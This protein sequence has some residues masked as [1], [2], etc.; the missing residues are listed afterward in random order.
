VA[1]HHA[2]GPFG[3]LLA[4]AFVAACSSPGEGAPATPV[5]TATGHVETACDMFTPDDLAGFLHQP[6]VGHGEG[7]TI[8]YLGVDL[9]HCT[10]TW[11]PERG[12]IDL[13]LLTAPMAEGMTEDA[14]AEACPGFIWGAPRPSA[15]FDCQNNKYRFE[16]GDQILSIDRPAD[17]VAAYLIQQSLDAHLVQFGQFGVTT[18][19]AT[20][21]L[22]VRGYSPALDGVDAEALL[23]RMHER[24]KD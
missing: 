3:I 4:A 8:A 12:E 21:W 14:I 20:V 24:L 15:L 18:D 11:P 2:R 16:P 19:E 7:E 9:S 6:V 5:D 10:Y 13:Y 23:R 22:Y 17:A 1:G